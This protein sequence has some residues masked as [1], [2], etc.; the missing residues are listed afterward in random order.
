M[1]YGGPRLTRARYPN[2]DPANPYGGGW[3]FADGKPLPMYE[4]QPGED[5]QTLRFKEADRRTWSRPS[6]VEVFVF[7]RYNWWNNI[8]PI[9]SVD[10][11][12]R[13]IT[14]S[15][16]ASYPIRPG[17]RYYFQGALEELDAPG[18]WYLDR[19]SRTL[20]V[21][22]PGRIDEGHEIVAPSSVP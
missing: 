12:D 17:D 14:L 4:D 1:F 18:E 15:G 21:W 22:P 10:P 3:A 16:D 9:A 2:F 20:Y 6:E 5:R 11:G 13:K 7:P 8:I 19:A